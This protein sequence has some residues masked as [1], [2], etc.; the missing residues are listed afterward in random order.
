MTLVAY[1]VNLIFTHELKCETN[2]AV[3]CEQ[4]P[5]YR[6]VSSPQHFIYVYDYILDRISCVIRD[7]IV[8]YF[9]IVHQIIFC[10][11]FSISKKN[12]TVNTDPCNGVGGT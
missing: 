1:N 6:V 10:N 12:I 9:V 4:R 3:I 7:Y 11:M 8:L 2:I 5:R